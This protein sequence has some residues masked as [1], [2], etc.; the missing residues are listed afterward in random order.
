MSGGFYNTSGGSNIFVGSYAGNN[1]NANN[2][3]FIGYSSGQ[4]NTSGT[5]NTY[6]GFSSGYT[7]QAGVNNVIIGDES[8]ENGNPVNNSVF[9]GQYCGRFTAGAN[10]V[11]IGNGTGYNCQGSNNVLI[12]YNAGSQSTV[13]NQLFIDVSNTSNPLIWGDFSARQL[14]FNGKVGIIAANIEG[15]TCLSNA[16]GSNTSIAIGR[17]AI[18]G[19]LAICAAAGNW[20]S[21]TAAGDLALRAESNT[22]KIH[23][24]V[25]AGANP[26]ITIANSCVGIN[27]V[28]P[29]NPLIV[30]TNTS[31]GNGAYVTT[32][33]VWT[34]TS[35]RSFK[36]RFSNLN[37]DEVIDKIEN[38]EIKAWFYKQTNEYHI[39]PVAEDFYNAFGTGD[40]NSENVNKYLSSS[41]VAGVTM[42]AVKELIKQ[43]HEQNQVI[44]KQQLE[45]E[46]IR[47]ELQH[48][49]D[50]LEKR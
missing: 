10:N 45:I 42:L 30:G 8:G 15:I 41:D 9:V 16:S 46:S 39:G 37:V 21:N 11:F 19:H 2:N 26:E 32:G 7:N 3:T 38:M 18:E 40:R 47:T 6:M 48:I 31:N 35:S 22:Q 49:K 13:S 12:G 24:G 25:N 44:S 20:F 23:L 33:G 1:N 43:N 17:V 29:L 34:N 36:D 5:S 28:N 27:R 4:G 14:Q 50:I